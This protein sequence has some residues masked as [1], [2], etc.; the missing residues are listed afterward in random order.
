MV[1]GDE[2]MSRKPDLV[3]EEILDSSHMLKMDPKSCIEEDALKDL[4]IM[5]FILLYWK[6]MICLGI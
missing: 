3:I 6:L 5:F 2:Y 1:H 4:K